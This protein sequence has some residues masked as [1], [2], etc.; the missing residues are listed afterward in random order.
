[1]VDQSLNSN[2][3]SQ[4]CPPRETPSGGSQRWRF[5]LLLAV[6]ILLASGAVLAWWRGSLTSPGETPLDGELNIVVR[7][8]G[9]VKDNLRVEDPGALPV[10]ANDWMSVEVHLNQPAFTYLVWLDCNGQA[11]PL[12]PWNYDSIEVTDLDQPPPARRPAK[13]II[14]PTLG[15]G[16]QF[17][18]RGGLETVLLLARRTPLSE[19]TRLGTLLGS[20]PT[21]KLGPRDELAILGLG[22][23]SGSVSMML[24]SNRGPEEGVRAADEPLRALLVRLRDYFELIRAVRFA[25]AGEEATSAAR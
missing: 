10:R 18:P 20:L 7:S 19:S 13:V 6:L 5:W 9:G 15:T 11:V 4:G 8:A 1:M 17:G 22:G 21:A 23:G 25:H 24:A 14:S 12:Y 16:W 2:S 3:D